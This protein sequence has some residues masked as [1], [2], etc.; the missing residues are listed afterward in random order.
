MIQGWVVKCMSQRLDMKIKKV[1]K[2]SVL[3]GI[4]PDDMKT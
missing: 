4:N 1:L 3:S 2:K